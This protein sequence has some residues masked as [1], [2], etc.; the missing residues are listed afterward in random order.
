MPEADLTSVKT[1]I[2]QV[3][4][5]IT[6]VVNALKAPTISPDDLAYFRGK[7]K[8]LRDKEKQIRDKELI[9][10]QS[11][12]TAAS[13]CFS[14]VIFCSRVATHQLWRCLV[15]PCSLFMRIAS[16]SSVDW[17]F[18]LAFRISVSLASG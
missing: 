2:T 6:E 4:H 12:G 7:E 9:L 15:L 3:E 10:L 14:L 18:P 1:Q 11:S 8:Q 17:R 16:A 5:D 13:C